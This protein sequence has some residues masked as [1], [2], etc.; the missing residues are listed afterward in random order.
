MSQTL[1]M[2]EN[3]NELLHGLR[4]KGMQS[5]FQ[6]LAE[7]KGKTDIVQAIEKSFQH[8]RRIKKFWSLIKPFKQ[9]RYFRRVAKCLEK[10]LLRNTIL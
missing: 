5:D 2:I 3:V 4:L 10:P 7:E 6:K 9:R 1:H 8:T